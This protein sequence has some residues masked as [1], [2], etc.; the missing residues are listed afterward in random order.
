[1]GGGRV[2][3]GGDGFARGESIDFTIA[4]IELVD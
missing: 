2:K 1:M 3:S 4:K